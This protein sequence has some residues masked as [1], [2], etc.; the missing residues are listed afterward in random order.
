MMGMGAES[1]SNHMIVE[2]MKNLLKGFLGQV[3]QG[4]GSWPSMLNHYLEKS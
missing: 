2:C 3:Y 4:L 1:L